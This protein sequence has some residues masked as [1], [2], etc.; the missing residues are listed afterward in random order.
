[1]TA[2]SIEATSKRNWLVLLGILLSIIGIAIAGY[3]TYVKVAD[4]E[5]ICVET[6]SLDCNAVQASAYSSLLG[7]PVAVLGLG[8]YISFLLLFLLGD[9]IGFLAEYGSIILFGLT[10]F[11]VI[12]SAYLTYIEAFVLEK[13]CQYCIVS[14]VLM[15]GLFIISIMRVLQTDEEM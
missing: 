14:A 12:Y 15:V 6:G 5:I 8:A 13:W 3:L 4:T 2:T 9:R 11:G 10:L 1:M 7:I